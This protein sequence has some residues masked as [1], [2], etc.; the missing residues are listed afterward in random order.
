MV[1][2]LPQPKLLWLASGAVVEADDEEIVDDVEEL[3]A[4]LFSSKA[5]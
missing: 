2:E 3:L 5:E 4:V 1:E